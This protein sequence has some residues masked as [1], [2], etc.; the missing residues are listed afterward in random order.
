MSFRRLPV[1]PPAALVLLSGLAVGH[2]LGLSPLLLPTA[3]AQPADTPHADTTHADTSA[4]ARSGDWLVLPYA[5]YEPK[6]RLSA[7]VVAGFYRPDRPG[8]IPSSVQSVVTVTQERQVIIQVTPEIY[9]DDGRHRL[10][11]EIA[12]SRFPDQF[13]GIGGDTPAERKEDFTS[14]FLTLE[15]TAQRR[16]NAGIPG[17]LQVGPRAYLRAESVTELADDGTLATGRIAGADGGFTAGLGAGLLWEDRDNIYYPRDGHFAEA[18]AVWHSAALGS[19]FTFGRF[20]SDLRAYRSAGPVVVAGNVYVEGVAGTPPFQILPLLGGS[21]RMR[22]YRE[23]RYRDRLYW[24]TQAEVRAPLFWRFGAA[25][26]ASAGEVGPRIGSDLFRNVQ[27]AAGLGGRLR[28]NDEGVRGRVDL[29][30]GAGGLELYLSL[31][32]A[33]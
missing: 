33:F 4:S 32:E 5:S 14:R 30:Y 20:V 15:A 3:H 27:W 28:L 8:R 29:A 7:G 9:L 2:L 10:A 6:T 25:A 18:S 26:F 1:L 12:I 11:G 31:L 21:D 23:G 19:D 16:V 13:F 17:A 22:G 24:T